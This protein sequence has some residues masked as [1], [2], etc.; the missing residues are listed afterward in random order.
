[1]RM[2]QT[3]AFWG[4]ISLLGIAPLRAET[5]SM[6]P[7]DAQHAAY[8]QVINKNC[9]I[10]PNKNGQKFWAT[11]RQRAGVK[12]TKV[13]VRKKQLPSGNVDHVSVYET[14]GFD[15]VYKIFGPIAEPLWDKSCK[16]LYKDAQAKGI[17]QIYY[18]HISFKN[19]KIQKP[20]KPPHY[21]VRVNGKIYASVNP[22]GVITYA[23]GRDTLYHKA[24]VRY[25]IAVG[26]LEVM[27]K[28]STSSRR[29]ALNKRY[30]SEE[31][32]LIAFADILGRQCQLKMTTS[33]RK[34]YREIQMRSVT[35][36]EKNL[37][38]IE[39][40]Y[41]RLRAADHNP[42]VYKTFSIGGR[43]TYNHRPGD[44][45]HLL[46][47]DV[48]NGIYQLPCEAIIKRAKARNIYAKLYRE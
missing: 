29:T 27:G 31:V 1:M 14:T 36:G 9:D 45:L 35:F 5:F 41:Y 17:W 43:T 39:R 4:I 3:L 21:L 23:K 28:P 22:D 33:A 11:I 8:M 46:V 16:A 37:N 25:K 6:T 34:I 15:K 32:Q 13:G 7:E 44:G 40:E 47:N 20:K 2:I 24:M 30:T 26:D 48:I 19:G 38:F 12:T 10:S 42:L 18:S